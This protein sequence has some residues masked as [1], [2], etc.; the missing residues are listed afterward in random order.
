MTRER[1][2]AGGTKAEVEVEKEEHTASK[3]A[4]KV[5]VKDVHLALG[6][7]VRLAQSPSPSSSSLCGLI[8]YTAQY[9]GSRCCFRPRSGFKRTRNLFRFPQGKGGNGVGA[10]DRKVPSVSRGQ[11]CLG[12]EVVTGTARR[13]ASIRNVKATPQTCPQA[14]IRTATASTQIYMHK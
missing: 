13:Q 4:L 7:W 3:K 11:P 12:M 8:E 14:A 2:Q 10:H 6:L 5:F 1:D 9:L